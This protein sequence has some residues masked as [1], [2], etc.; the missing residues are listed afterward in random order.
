MQ[1]IRERAATGHHT[2]PSW[3][4][5]SG[6]QVEIHVDRN[7]NLHRF[8]VQQCRLI[9]PLTDGLKRCID[10]QRVPRDGAQSLHA[11]IGSDNGSKFHHARNAGLTRQ[12]WVWRPDLVN[13]LWRP[14]LTAD[15]NY[16][17]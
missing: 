11:S 13:Q 16:L 6:H 4:R 5:L 15:D 7:G 3:V 9:T 10:Q 17:R 14:Y 8:A 12:L 1:A 2:E